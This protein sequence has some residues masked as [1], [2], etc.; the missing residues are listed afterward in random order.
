M[1]AY[2]LP[3]H[4]RIR[5]TK[6]LQKPLPYLATL[7]KESIPWE[8]IDMDFMNLNQSAHGT[9]QYGGINARLNKKNKVVVGYWERSEVQKQSAVQNGWM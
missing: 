8:S 1:D 9:G 2:V 4:I 7:F 3:C 5:G 6:L